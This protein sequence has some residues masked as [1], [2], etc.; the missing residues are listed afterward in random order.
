MNATSAFATT[1][2]LTAGRTAAA[3]IGLALMGMIPP[4]LGETPSA[5]PVIAVVNGVQVRESDLAVVDQ[6]MGRNIPSMDRGERR[7][8][9]LG[10]VIDGIL[11][12]QIAKERNIVDQADIERRITFARNQGLADNLLVVAGKGAVTDES[13][14][15]L[16][17]EI[18]AK[19]PIEPEVH[20]RQIFFRVAN[21]SDEAA[22]KAVQNKAEAAMKRLHDG[23][24]FAAVCATLSDDR[25]T[26]LNGGDQGWHVRG[27]LGKEIFDAAVALKGGEVSPPIKT[28]AGLHIIKLEDRRDRKPLAFE[29]IKDKLA[30]IVET[31]ARRE[32]ISKARESAKID[33]MDTVK[34]AP[35]SN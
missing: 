11:L 29:Q 28:A 30:V 1:R 6:M 4:S 9:V 22:V 3:A 16:Y 31:K 32:L 5:D 27:E 10:L 25:A 23:E 26:A 19:T 15:K 24:D 35:K 14:H 33:L 12:A 20:L 7:E 17:D 2:L 21:A 18:K 13:E 8:S 34:A